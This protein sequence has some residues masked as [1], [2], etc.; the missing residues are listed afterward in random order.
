MI[1]SKRYKFDLGQNNLD[2]AQNKQP[3]TIEMK[4]IPFDIF[5]NIWKIAQYLKYN[6]FLKP[7]LKYYLQNTEEILV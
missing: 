4:D 3:R 5:V 1:S 6:T 7:H 2:L